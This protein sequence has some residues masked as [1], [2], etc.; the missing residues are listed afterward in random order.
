MSGAL[1]AGAGVG[2]GTAS[3][4]SSSGTNCSRAAGGGGGGQGAGGGGGVRQSK[5][6][7]Q[8]AACRLLQLLLTHLPTHLSEQQVQELHRLAPHRLRSDPVPQQL[9]HLQGQRTER[10][11]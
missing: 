7:S 1:P 4:G 6:A 3:A 11:R 2:G 10:G 8:I 9:A 5:V